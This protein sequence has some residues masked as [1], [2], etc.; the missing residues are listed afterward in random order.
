MK[1]TLEVPDNL[2]EGEALQFIKEGLAKKKRREKKQLESQGKELTAGQKAN[3][4]YD[5]YVQRYPTFNAGKQ[6]STA[7]AGRDIKHLTA[8]FKADPTLT[9]ARI[10]ELLNAFLA[11]KSRFHVAHGHSL[12]KFDLNATYGTDTAKRKPPPAK[13]ALQ[14]SEQAMKNGKTEAAH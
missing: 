4:T 8:M 11:D 9:G 5:W 13:S 12:N 6:Y 3:K 10:C 1:L 14:L 7:Y 2:T